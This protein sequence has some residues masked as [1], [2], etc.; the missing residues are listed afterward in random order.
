M[1]S[2]L[3]QWY[4]LAKLKGPDTEKLELRVTDIE[5]IVK[6]KP[7]E[8][9][10]DCIRI[11]LGKKVN[12]INFKEEFVKIF[13]ESDPYFPPN[14]NDLEVRILAGAVLYRFAKAAKL[15]NRLLGLQAIRTGIFG[16]NEESFINHDIIEGVLK[17]LNEESIA[18]RE[19]SK[20]DLLKVTFDP[21][22]TAVDPTTVTSKFSNVND[23]LK[24]I[25]NHINTVVGKKISLVDEE[26]NIHWWIFRGFSSTKNELFAKIDPTE[27]P[28][29]LAMELS[30]L[31]KYAP[32]P[33]PADQFISK[34]LS[35][36]K[37]PGKEITI[38]DFVNKIDK[39]GKMQFGFNPGIFGNLTPL[40]TAIVNSKEAD[41]VETWVQPF[42]KLC[43]IKRTKK[44]SPKDLALQLYNESLILKY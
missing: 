22:I 10:L 39:G 25:V 29:V 2:N 21:E 6:N 14:N 1:V 9:I 44:V 35:D 36:S 4:T 24:S 37:N 19:N 5:N 20:Q 28:F 15:K 43:S 18:I 34:I 3:A 8:W 12:N 30:A 40:S 26:S 33:Y 27:I 11:F 16:M 41:D 17:Q 31:T 23:S 38:I 7:L 13:L 42:E 32:G